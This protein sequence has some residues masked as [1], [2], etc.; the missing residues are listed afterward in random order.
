MDPIFCLTV[1]S[2]SCTFRSLRARCLSCNP[3]CQWWSSTDWTCKHWPPCDWSSSTCQ[4]SWQPFRKRSEH[5]IMRSFSR[6]FYYWRP[7]YTAAWT[8]SVHAR[9]LAML[10]NTQIY[11]VLPLT[12]ARNQ[13]GNVSTEDAVSLHYVNVSMSWWLISFLRYGTW[14]IDRLFKLLLLNIVVTIFPKM[15]PSY[16]WSSKKEVKYKSD[17]VKVTH[18]ASW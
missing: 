12:S 5:M 11:S 7:D 4:S 16:L 14:L 8:N 6:G 17:M 9:C 10:S 3:F 18:S 2:L 1:S 15:S 13:A